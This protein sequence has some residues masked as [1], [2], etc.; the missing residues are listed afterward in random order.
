MR[1]YFIISW[2][3]AKDSV[4]SFHILLLSFILHS[5]DS[6]WCIEDLRDLLLHLHFD[7]KIN[8]IFGGKEPKFALYI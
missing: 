6:M 1:N 3:L 7:E 5:E 4:R 2:G 8:I